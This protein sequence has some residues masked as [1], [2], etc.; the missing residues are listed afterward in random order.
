MAGRE[1]V[2]NDLQDAVNDNWLWQHAGYYALTMERAIA[3]LKEQDAV[4]PISPMDESDLYRCGNCNF[5]LFRA[6]HENYCPNC[7]RPLKWEPDR[8]KILKGLECCS[9]GCSENCPYF[10]ID[11]CNTLLSKDVLTMIKD[12]KGR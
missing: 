2:I 10:E 11:G 12:Q 1:K 8:V 6:A 5:Q 9:K 7:G 3:L 4:E